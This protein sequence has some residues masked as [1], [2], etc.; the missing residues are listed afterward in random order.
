MGHITKKFTKNDADL[1]FTKTKTKGKRRI[2][3]EGFMKGCESIAAKKYTKTH[4]DEQ[5]KKF[6]QKSKPIP[7]AKKKKNIDVVSRLTDTT[8]YGG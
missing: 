4:P 2:D 5:L 8:N 6:L 1:V 7:V 3:F